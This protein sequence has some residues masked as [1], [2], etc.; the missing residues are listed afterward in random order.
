[1]EMTPAK[2]RVLEKQGT[3]IALHIKYAGW[4]VKKRSNLLVWDVS[5]SI[6]MEQGSFTY[7][8]EDGWTGEGLD[9]AKRV[10]IRLP[11]SVS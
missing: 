3:E 2:Q 8:D 11:E 4:R 7:N 1:M 9:A 10:G 5:T 6:G